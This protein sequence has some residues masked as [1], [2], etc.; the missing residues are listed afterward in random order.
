MP[1]QGK[2][3]CII[4]NNSTN[5]ILGAR[6]I[7][8]SSIVSNVIG[9]IVSI[10]LIIG[11]VKDKAALL[12]PY[13]VCSVIGIVLMIIL[14]ILFFVLIPYVPAK[15]TGGFIPLVLLAI[16]IYFCLVVIGHYKKLKTEHSYPIP[17]AVVS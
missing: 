9:L 4:H 11:A 6:G 1:D 3:L 15:I 13:I 7:Y 14:S 17:F 8:I 2:T 10:L 5:G 12:V 16:P